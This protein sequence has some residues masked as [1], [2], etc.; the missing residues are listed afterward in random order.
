MIR[1]VKIPFFCL[2]LSAVILFS[3]GC[4]LMGQAV[5]DAARKEAEKRGSEIS[6][7]ARVKPTPAEPTPDAPEKTIPVGE[8][9]AFGDWE[10]TVK[11]CGL[12]NDWP[13]SDSEYNVMTYNPDEGNIYFAVEMS[14]KNNG[15][16]AETFLQ[17]FSTKQSAKLI[18]NGEYT[19]TPV[20]LLGADHTVGGRSVGPLSTYTGWL[21]FSVPEGLE[22]AFVLELDGKG[23]QKQVMEV[24]APKEPEDSS[25]SSEAQS[26][27][28]A[29]TPVDEKQTDKE[30]QNA[31]QNYWEVNVVSG[32]NCKNN[33]NYPDENATPYSSEDGSFLIRVEVEIVNNDSAPHAFVSQSDAA[34]V[35][36]SGE[37]FPPVPDMDD[38]ALIFNKEAGPGELVQGSMFF[39]IP[40]E[41]F[42][43]NFTLK[44]ACNEEAEYY[45]FSRM[46]GF[47]G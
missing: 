6:S 38:P 19:Y 30:E 31:V 47:G 22:G 37:E 35:S 9:V 36:D 11:G 10:V 27:V 28:D 40:L 17:T 41:S 43:D 33:N 21:V 34:L 26:K 42:N 18:Y 25:K 39:Q 44:L 3:S 16:T 20:N 13:V 24:G 12:K 46:G 29:E 14:I 45:A 4:G 15:K 1:K 5:Y 2:A 23:L 32:L 7:E 8:A